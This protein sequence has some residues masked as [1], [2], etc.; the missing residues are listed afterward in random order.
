MKKRFKDNI[1]F[2]LSFVQ[3]SII[4]VILANCISIVSKDTYFFAD[5]LEVDDNLKNKVFE[6]CSLNLDPDDFSLKANYYTKEHKHQTSHFYL[7]DFFENFHYNYLPDAMSLGY[8]QQ[9]IPDF[10]PK[11]NKI[12]YD[13]KGNI[14]FFIKYIPLDGNNEGFCLYNPYNNLFAA[15]LKENHTRWNIYNVFDTKRRVIYHC[16]AFGKCNGIFLI[17]RIMYFFE[18]F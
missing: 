4:I 12:V 15:A 6:S 14:S 3:I 10:Y 7:I 11:K 1:L 16:G 9:Y 5:K 8:K 17:P 2:F 13:K 18:N